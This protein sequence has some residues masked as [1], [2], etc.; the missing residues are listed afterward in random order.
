MSCLAQ[1]ML[2]NNTA[3]DLLYFSIN[4]H[5]QFNVITIKQCN[6]LVET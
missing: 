1:E 5:G 2:W 6:D 3:D 4:S